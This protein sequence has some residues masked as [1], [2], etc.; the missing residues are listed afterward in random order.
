MKLFSATI[1]VTGQF[2]IEVEASI[3]KGSPCS[4]KNSQALK[5]ER[6][7]D[8]SFYLIKT[9]VES[10]SRTIQILSIEFTIHTEKQFP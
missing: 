7:R 9:R 5:R 10:V 4:P 2:G 3:V 1:E 6:E 8:Y